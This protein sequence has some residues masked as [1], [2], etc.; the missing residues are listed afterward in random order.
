MIHD[1]NDTTA[2]TNSIV[3]L[4]TPSSDKNSQLTSKLK[5]NEQVSNKNKFCTVLRILF[6][7]AF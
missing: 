3:M 4:K 6:S 5:T 2:E 1:Q 7:S